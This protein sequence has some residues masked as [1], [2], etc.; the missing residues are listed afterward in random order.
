MSNVPV[1]AVKVTNGNSLEKCIYKVTQDTLNDLHNRGNKTALIQLQHIVLN[2]MAKPVHIFRGLK[3]PMKV[4]EDGH[5]A[6]NFLL[7]CLK[8]QRDWMWCG[9][10]NRANPCQPP[11]NQ[12]F[13]VIVNESTHEIVQWGW[14]S[15][16]TKGR[17]DA[18]LYVDHLYGDTSI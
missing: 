8:G 18:A 15:E 9:D 2:E 11:S 12:V 10:I 14:T 16:S 6:D 5:A 1:S 7:Y 3:R 17:P 4:G 13:F